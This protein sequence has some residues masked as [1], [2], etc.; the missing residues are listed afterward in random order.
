MNDRREAHD[1]FSFARSIR[2]KAA[3]IA[4]FAQTA[5]ASRVERHEEETCFPPLD[6]SSP[7][8]DSA[9]DQRYEAAPPLPEPDPSPGTQTGEELLTRSVFVDDEVPTIDGF[10]QVRA[11]PDPRGRP[12]LTFRWRLPIETPLALCVHIHAFYL[13]VLPEL[14]RPLRELPPSTPILISVQSPEDAQRAMEVVDDALGETWPRHIT[15]VP[16][17]GRNFLPFSAT[18]ASQIA[19]A[20]LVLHLHTKKSLFC[21]AEQIG[22]RQHMTRALSASSGALASAVALFDQHPEVGMLMADPYPLLPV[23]A[24][25]WL[26]NQPHGLSILRRM[27]SPAAPRGYLRYPVGGM[28]WSRSAALQPLFSAGIV[29]DDFEVEQGQTDGTLAHAIE[30]A[31]AVSTEHAGYRIVELAHDDEQWRDGWSAFEHGHFGSIDWAALHRQ[32]PELRLVS[33]DIFDTVNLRPCLDPSLLQRQ[34]LRA[35]SEDPEAAGRLFRERSLAETTLREESEFSNDPSLVEIYDRLGRDFGW[36]ADLR[37]AAFQSELDVERR[38]VFENVDAIAFVRAAQQAGIRTIAIT[39]TYLPVGFIKELLGRIGLDATDHVYVSNDVRARKDTGALWDHVTAIE[40]C[41]ASGWLHVGDNEASDIQSASDRG[42][43]VGYVPSARSIAE[44]EGIHALAFDAV[45]GP[46]SL[47]GG[48]SQVQLLSRLPRGQSL[49]GHELGEFVIGPLVSGFACWVREQIRSGDFDEIW[50]HSR[51]CFHFIRYLGQL[52]PNLAD[53]S[54]PILRYF[55]SSRAATVGAAHEEQLDVDLILGSGVHE[56]TFGQFMFDRTGF[57]LHRDPA[58]VPISLPNDG[59]KVRQLLQA[60]APELITF[61]TERAECLRLYTHGLGVRPSDRIGVVDWGYAGTSLRAMS[62]VL[63]Q[64]LTGLFGCATSEARFASG[65]RLDVRSAYGGDASLSANFFYAISIV[66]EL[67][68]SED[69]ERLAGFAAVDGRAVPVT[70]PGSKP[71]D[72]SNSLR[73]QVRA[74]VDA[75]HDTIVRRLHPS[76]LDDP[77]DPKELMRQIAVVADSCCE[78]GGLV[79]QLL[80]EHEEVEAWSELAWPSDE[81]LRAG[82][83]RLVTRDA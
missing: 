31:V 43:R 40:Q 27:G 47:L 80:D 16:N 37:S 23:W 14:V 28:F 58:R 65:P 29:E 74:G 52:F 39:D 17:R 3:A 73:A 20:D 1:R 46:G 22:W 35:V 77:I 64:H 60:V 18:F 21:G 62:R 56:S 83:T 70:I 67:T 72:N 69:A 71:F 44:A 33:F 63:P 55:P 48:A 9:H 61:S 54:H 36:S 2:T 12:V 38:S 24:S 13:D 30:R 15:I 45:E 11:K 25:H 41:N 34:A 8:A 53:G 42:M 78:F 81:Q 7:A 75:H 6:A 26:G 59:R 50:F 19:A 66:L 4:R 51:D 32:L 49:T 5:Q 79:T 82:G 10:A 68:L 76:S 57:I